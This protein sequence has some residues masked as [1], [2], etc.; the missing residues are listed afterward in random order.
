MKSYITTGKHNLVI[1]VTNI[2]QSNK[3]TKSLTLT[4]EFCSLRYF[5]APVTVPPVPIP[6]TRKSTFPPVPFH[7]SGPVAS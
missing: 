5:P 6:E 4:S 1:E 2:L 7:I 3:T